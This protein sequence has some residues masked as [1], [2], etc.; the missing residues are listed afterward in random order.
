[1]VARDEP[2][3]AEPASAEVVLPPLGVVW[4]VPEP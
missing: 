1:V 2:W 4:L 3:G